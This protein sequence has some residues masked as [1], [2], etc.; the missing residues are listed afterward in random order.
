MSAASYVVVFRS[1]GNALLRPGVPNWRT[2]ADMVAR[3][4]VD[5]VTGETA[6]LA[7]A[8]AADFR[9]GVSGLVAVPFVD[10][11]RAYGGVR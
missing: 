2:R 8:G 4:S 7:L 1:T 5:G 10:W 3:V 11:A 6:E 9:R